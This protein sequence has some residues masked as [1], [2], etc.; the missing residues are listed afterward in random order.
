MCSRRRCRSGG[1]RRRLDRPAGDE[2]GHYAGASAVGLTGFDGS[3]LVVQRLYLVANCV[4]FVIRFLIFHYVL[5]ADRGSKVGDVAESAPSAASGAAIEAGAVGDGLVGRVG[6]RPAAPRRRAA[7]PS[8]DTG[9]GGPSAADL[10][11][12]R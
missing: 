9:L 7:R 4:T 2:L 1:L 5:F 11:P 8:E 12:R 10:R 6:D 3:V